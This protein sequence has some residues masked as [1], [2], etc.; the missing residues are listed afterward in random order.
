MEQDM[1]TSKHL[2]SLFREVHISFLHGFDYICQCITYLKNVTSLVLFVQKHIEG[3]LANG[4]KLFSSPE[5]CEFT[6][7]NVSYDCHQ[8][9][10]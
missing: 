7:I 5:F 4:C 9:S 8:C 2:M 1:L 6:A 3:A 10:S